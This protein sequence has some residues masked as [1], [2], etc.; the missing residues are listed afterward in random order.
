MDGPKHKKFKIAEELNPQSSNYLLSFSGDL[1]NNDLRLLNRPSLPNET[2]NQNGFVPNYENMTSDSSQVWTRPSSDFTNCSSYTVEDELKNQVNTNSHTNISNGIKQYNIPN[3]QEGP[4]SSYNG[5]L[6][7]NVNNDKKGFNQFPSN[8]NETTSIFENYPN[9]MNVGMK[10]QNYSNEK[11]GASCENSE[12]KPECDLTESTSNAD[13]APLSKKNDDRVK[14]PMNAFM[15]WSRGQRRQMAVE[16]PKMHNSEISKRL[17]AVWKNLSDTEKHPFID[18]AKRLRDQ[19]MKDHPD[20]KYRPRRKS[21]NLLKKDKYGMN[22]I[23]HQVAN[24][25]QNCNQNGHA[26]PTQINSVGRSDIYGKQMGNTFMNN[27]MEIPQNNYLFNGMNP[28]EQQNM[29]VSPYSYQHINS[30]FQP[31]SMYQQMQPNQTI[32]SHT[33]IHN[34]IQGQEI[35]NL[36]SNTR[37]YDQMPY[38]GPNTQYLNNYSQ[39]PN[40]TNFMRP[41]NLNQLPNISNHEMTNSTSAHDKNNFSSSQVQ[42]GQNLNFNSNRLFSENHNTNS[43]ECD[44]KRSI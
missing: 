38:C 33:D 32:N 21:K 10:Y 34:R 28:F 43:T 30:Q 29:N 18:E 20:Y 23:N 40:S 16:N 8:Q 7:N 42:M 9:T 17:G 1:Q 37:M 14:R 5:H 22:M 19:H 31:V 27:G 11:I 36:N 41:Q 26:V 44:S 39:N 12:I 6:E 13:T 3:S 15:V 4:P 35:R 2:H 24:H 25:Q